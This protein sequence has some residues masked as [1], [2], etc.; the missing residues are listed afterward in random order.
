M[1]RFESYRL[2]PNINYIIAFVVDG[3]NDLEIKGRTRSDY[4][5]QISSVAENGLNMPAPDGSIGC[6]GSSVQIHLNRSTWTIVD[7][8][9]EIY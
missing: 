5:W 3:R 9:H 8:M 2:R 4:P 1:I 7:N 6:N